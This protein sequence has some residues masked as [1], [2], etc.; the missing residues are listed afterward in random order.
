MAERH[1]DHWFF[2]LKNSTKAQALSGGPIHSMARVVE[3]SA[4]VLFLV[5]SGIHHHGNADSEA[6]DSRRFGFHCFP[7]LFSVK[8]KKKIKQGKLFYLLLH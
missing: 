5:S 4:K 3:R 7:C 1:G 8:A 6:H 2:R